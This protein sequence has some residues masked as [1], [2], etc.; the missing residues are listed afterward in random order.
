MDSKIEKKKCIQI[1]FF[2]LLATS[3]YSQDVQ[4]TVQNI[5]ANVLIDGRY[6]L[7]Y[8]QFDA[9]TTNASIQITCTKTNRN[10]PG[11]LFAFVNTQNASVIDCLSY[12]S[13][14]FFNNSIYCT[15]RTFFYNL[16]LESQGTNAFY[17][18]CGIQEKL[19]NNLE[20]FY[21][22]KLCK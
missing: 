20:T 3:S 18:Q 10:Q 19:F 21:L 5:D 17:I 4:I 22:P 15:Q 7:T 11:T 12:T 1:I 9:G 6:N 8:A 13:P 14:Q 16:A 2:V